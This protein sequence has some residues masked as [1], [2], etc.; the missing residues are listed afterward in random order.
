MTSLKK[1][2]SI[3]VLSLAL[4]A[5]TMLAGSPAFVTGALAE[6]TVSE[7]DQDPAPT[8]DLDVA[9]ED[10]NEIN[11]QKKADTCAEVSN[12]TLRVSRC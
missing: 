10:A 8:D 2:V 7:D 1:F 4:P 3:L 11:A 5:S 9:E 6:V 12:K